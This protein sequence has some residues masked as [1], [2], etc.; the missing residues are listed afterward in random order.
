MANINK[1][2]TKIKIFLMPY[3]SIFIGKRSALLA[4][5]KQKSGN[6]GTKKRVES[7][8]AFAQPLESIPLYSY[9]IK[10]KKNK[11]SVVFIVQSATSVALLLY[12]NT[13]QN[14]NGKKIL[15]VK[16]YNRNV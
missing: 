13:C 7:R 9:K 2:T 14:P 11:L 3:W 12:C 15:S 16:L 8:L 1:K 5:I 10:N 6:S 4:K